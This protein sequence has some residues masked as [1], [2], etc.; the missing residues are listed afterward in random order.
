MTCLYIRFN[1]GGRRGHDPRVPTR[2]SRV[3][4]RQQVSLC[5]RPELLNSIQEERAG[6]PSAVCPARKVLKLLP[7]LAVLRGR[8]GDLFEGG[9]SYQRHLVKSPRVDVFSRPA[10]P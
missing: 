10:F 3:K 9:G 4:A 5:G 1:S 2:V 8:T 6:L 7:K